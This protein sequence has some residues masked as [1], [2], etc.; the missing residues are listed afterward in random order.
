MNRLDIGV[1]LAKALA[2]LK[3]ADNTMIVP[4]QGGKNRVTQLTQHSRAV[5]RK[6]L[7]A[8]LYRMNK[9]RSKWNG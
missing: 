4:S 6:R 3:T 7:A 2:A 5:K 8:K 9:R 1:A